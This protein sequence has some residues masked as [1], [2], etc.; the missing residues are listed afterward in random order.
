MLNNLNS[1]GADTYQSWSDE[2]R[3]HEIGNLVEGF[4]SGLPVQILCQLAT[5]IAGTPA[6]AS[7]HL[8]AFMSLEERKAIVKKESGTNKALRSLLKATLL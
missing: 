6:L 7:E 8:S 3:R 5:Q 4:K 1:I 2:Q